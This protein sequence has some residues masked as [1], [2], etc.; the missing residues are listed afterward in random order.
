[1]REKL[2][3]IANFMRKN[4]I[5]DDYELHIS[6]KDEQFTRFAQNAITQHINGDYIE[7]SYRCIKNKKIGSA[8]TRQVD[9]ESLLKLIK[10]AEEIAENNSPD[11]NITLSMTK[12]DYPETSNYYP[13]IEKLN[14]EKI[15]QIVK[16]C[17]DFAESKQGQLSGI[18]SK[19]I[20]E[21]IYATGNGF[22]GYYRFSDVEMSM[23]LRKDHIETKVSYG[24]NDFAK[25]SV[26]NLLSDL[27]KQFDALKDM[28]EMDYETIPVILRPKAVMQ[29]FYYLVWL[30]DRKNADEGLTPFTE[31]LNKKFLGEK[32]NLLSSMEDPDLMKTPFS[33][34][35][36]HKTIQWI[37]NGTLLEMPT[38]RYWAQKNN[39]TPSNFFNIIIEGEGVSEEEM[40]KKV[41]RG[42]I[43][44]NL[45]YIR[46]NDL[47]T[48]DLT[49][50]TRDG[51][52]YFENGEVKYAVNNFRFNEQIHE[53]TQKILALGEC[54]QQDSYAK[55][56]AMLID[57]FT[58]VDKTTF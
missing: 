38:S 33:D 52:L 58:F 9:D 32:F 36:I 30:Y 55:V 28:R 34:N 11:P 44:N 41:D 20:G 7:V 46:L 3:T 40:M 27:G 16:K 6:Y 50:M 26:E 10:S 47:K 42:L 23:T 4:I 15:I 48:A 51:V 45:W 29:L 24:N 25:L 5:A 22:T 43:I 19:T 53:I 18:V 13:A 12:E 54:I 49:G 35:N 31:Q 8:S 56:P 37:K 2:T 21:Y 17:I 1:M 14:T 39:L 57:N